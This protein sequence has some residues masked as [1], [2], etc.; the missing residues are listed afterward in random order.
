[1]SSSA[2][3]PATVLEAF[4]AL[5]P[6]GTPLTTPEVAA[7]F[8]CTDR[9]VYNKLDALAEDGVLETK[10][11]GARGRVWWR[12]VCHSERTGGG[13]PRG[14]EDRSRAVL[15]AMDEG[16]LLADVAFDGDRE[17]I[18]IL[19]RD[20]NPAATELLGED[21]EGRWLTETDLSYG[22]RLYGILGRV[23]STGEGERLEWYAE[24]DDAWYD[25]YAFKPEGAGSRRVAV[26]F[27]DVTERKRAQQQLAEERDVF[28][29]GP[30]V[31]FRWDPD[32]GEGW[33]VE[34]VSGNVE[35]LLGYTAEELTE[36]DL[37]YTDLL[38]DEEIDRITREVEENSAGTTERFSHDPYRIRTRDGGVRW[39]QDTTN[40]VR[41][42]SGDITHYVGYLVDI[43]EL[44]RAKDALER[45]NSASRELMGAG[46]QEIGARV[47][48]ITGDVLDAEYT[49]VWHYD[50]TTGEFRQRTGRND[51]ETGTG[52]IRLPDG[53][54][55]QVWRAF[56]SADIDVSNDLPPAPESASSESTLRSRVLVP[57]GRHGVVCVGSTRTGAF[58][59][60][61]VDLVGALAA[62]IEAAWDRAEG[63]QRLAQQNEELARLDRL[64]G[65]IREVIDGLVEA[66]SLEEIDRAVCE[67]L[68]GS[69]QYE[70]AWIGERDPVT[71]T[72]TPREWAGIDSGY[73]DALDVP[74]DGTSS[75]RNPTATAVRTR[76]TQVVSD[77]ATETR[78]TPLRE[79]TL[80]QGARSCLA[81]PLV[82][83]ESLYGVLTVYADHSQPDERDH[84]VLAELGR[85]IA[86]AIAAVETRETLRTDRVVEL[87]LQCREANTPLCRLAR[88]AECEIEFE[89]LV[90]R[91]NGEPDVFVTASGVSPEEFRT[92]GEGSVAVEELLCLAEREGESLFR[93]RTSDPT[94]ASRFVEQGAVV[95]T[96]TIED[97]VA[98]SVVDLPHTVDV[99]EFIERMGRTGPDVELRARRTRERPLKTRRTFRTACEDRLTDKQRAALRT[100]YLSGFFESPRVRTGEEVAASLDVSQP[101]FANHLRAA[102]REVCELL[103]D[104]W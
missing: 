38:L 43:T 82:Y 15:E 51:P 25:F 64:N 81:V 103:F 69:D 21:V 61:T 62:T 48:T 100:A 5:A 71:D 89:G 20:S 91:S 13:R 16:F 74:T 53:F 94:L 33:P 52:T 95:H 59:E 96:L 39:V 35:D 83:E 57:L 80:E 65:L 88:Q 97:G 60:T 86:H 11:V 66:D 23:A 9:T 99:R 4:D 73:V 24:A 67:R 46:T 8:D 7:E 49:A 3:S 17:P 76:E 84:A 44:K 63:E 50:E 2:P 47:G 42:D 72:I 28:T 41:D 104:D 19:Y 101:T 79:A 75:E 87:T 29:E 40:I 10:K 22:S 26:V 93:A 70:F 102:Q 36:G 98:T 32:A 54:A 68:A 14:N 27:R 1:M 12:P 77:I 34:Y 45:L 18:D 85:T 6:P 56:V 58:D 30:A 37:T 78:F 55:E 92:A 90:S 31:V